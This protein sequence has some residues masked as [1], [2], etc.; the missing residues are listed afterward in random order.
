MCLKENVLEGKIC[1]LVADIFVSLILCIKQSGLSDFI[2]FRRP[3]FLY[4][5]C[6]FFSNSVAAVFWGN[7]LKIKRR[8]ERC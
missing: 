2:I 8:G 4:P 3:L 6:F 5:M 7:A 1:V